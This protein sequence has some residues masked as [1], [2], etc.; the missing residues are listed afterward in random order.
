MGA[1][2]Y[3]SPKCVIGLVM[4]ALALVFPL[5]AKAEIAYM[6]G[7]NISIYDGYLPPSRF[8][9]ILFDLGL[10]GSERDFMAGLAVASWD[11]RYEEMYGVQVSG[12]VAEAD[13]MYGLQVALYAAEVNKGF[14]GLQVALFN[15]AYDGFGVQIGIVNELC[16]NAK[17]IQIGILCVNQNFVSPL[18]GFSF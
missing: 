13:W 10:F 1:K 12:V 14:Y 18:L 4:L 3:S 15:A 9:V 17:G 5:F 2:T 16:D 8:G 11:S 6:P 7:A